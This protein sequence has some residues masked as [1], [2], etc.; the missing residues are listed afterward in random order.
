MA[1]PLTTPPGRFGIANVETGPHQY[2]ATMALAGLLNPFTGSATLGPLAVLVDHIAGFANHDR[3]PEGHWTVSSELAMEFA[4]DAQSVI[5]EDPAVPV[6]AVSRP[7]GAA[8]ATSLSECTL[9]HRG[10]EIGLATVR[11]FYI[12]AAVHVPGAFEEPSEPVEPLP[13]GL[14]GLM[15]VD[16]AEAGG[17]GVVLHQRAHSAVNNTLGAVH[18]GVAAAGLEL[19][20]SA[21]LNIDRPDTPL[22]TASLRINYLR[23]LIGGGSSHYTATPL[24][25]GRSSGVA[26]AKGIGD[27]G[28]VALTA[29]LTAYR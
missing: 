15:A 10:A 1:Y 18:G 27:D 4:P 23:R 26:E 17:T 3:R 29:R 14:A 6:L 16:V 24:H 2:A 8:G 12:T 13:T 5:A 19:V 11:T 25:A 22:L 9:T 20:G 28:K 21:A 7:V